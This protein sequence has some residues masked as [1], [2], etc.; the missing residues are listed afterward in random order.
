MVVSNLSNVILIIAVKGAARRTPINPQIIP[1][2]IKDKIIVIGCNPKLSPNILGSTKFPTIW[3]IIVGNII[4]NATSVGLKKNQSLDLDFSK[5]EKGKF[6]Y[7]VIYNPKETHFLKK[8]KENGNK[9]ENGK[10]MF[11]YQANQSFSIWN[12]VIPKIDK[13][14]LKI[15]EWLK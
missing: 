4:I 9:I 7:D 2:K 13:D 15:L 3:W 11:I 1:Q 5:I 10:Y 8:A 12:N 14:V 6:F